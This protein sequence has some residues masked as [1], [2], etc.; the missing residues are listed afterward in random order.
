[1]GVFEWDPVL[2]PSDNEAAITDL[3]FPVS[4]MPIVLKGAEA[5]I[6]AD[7]FVAVIEV[8]HWQWRCDG[9]IVFCGV[10]IYQIVSYG[11]LLCT[12]KLIAF[13]QIK[14]SKNSQIDKTI[15]KMA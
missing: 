3:P 9:R 15:F 5:M 1:M 4:P 7:V 12:D 8:C 13:Y 14:E 11:G 6:D 2:S 10:S